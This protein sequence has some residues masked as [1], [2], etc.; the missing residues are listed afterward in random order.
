MRC[1]NTVLNVMRSYLLLSQCVQTDIRCAQ[2]QFVS[3][4]P[5]KVTTQAHSIPFSSVTTLIVLLA[6]SLQ[7]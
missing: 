6:V 2:M 7:R 4:G 5:L 1:N 3:H